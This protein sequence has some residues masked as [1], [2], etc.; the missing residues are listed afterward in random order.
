MKSVVVYKLKSP[1]QITN[2]ALEEFKFS[3]CGDLDLVRMGY[4]KTFD[5]EYVSEV[6]GGTLMKFTKQI[7]KPHKAEIERQ[8]SAKI[9]EYEAEGVVVNKKF[10]NDLKDAIVTEL[11]PKTPP[12]EEK[13]YDVLIKDDKVYVEGGYK[14]AEE[15]MAVL[16]KALGSLPIIPLEVAKN[17]SEELTRFV[18]EELNTDKL[19][20]AD[21]CTLVT[22]EERKITVARDLFDSEAVDLAKEGATVTSVMLE[23]DGMTLFTVK[24]DLSISGIKYSKDLTSEVEAGDV[25]GTTLLQIKEVVNLIDALVGEFGGELIEEDE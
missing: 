3:Q 9:A 22:Q 12:E 7:K 13:H 4:S 17:V 14:L 1:I 8:L 11:L 16:R 20:L 18:S 5:G 19:V 24:D 23:Y 15:A 21:K 25:A 10:A 2:E 6:L